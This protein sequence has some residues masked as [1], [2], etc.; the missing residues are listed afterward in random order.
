MSAATGA[1]CDPVTS[2]VTLAVAGAPLS[3]RITWTLADAEGEAPL[4]PV[5]DQPNRWSGTI[6]PFAG[7]GEA[8]VTVELTSADGSPV[9]VANRLIVERC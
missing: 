1:D 8:V 5:A 7:P 9:T 4:E 3:G 2:E 6:G